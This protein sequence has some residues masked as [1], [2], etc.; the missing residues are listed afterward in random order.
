VERFL[1]FSKPVIGNLLL[2]MILTES[3]CF[4]VKIVY[5]PFLEALDAILNPN[6][7]SEVV[8]NQGLHPIL[9]YM[10]RDLLP[11]LAFPSH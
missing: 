10:N 7:H 11:L 9:A 5:L 4:E 2:A 6:L 1:P 3:L 8:E